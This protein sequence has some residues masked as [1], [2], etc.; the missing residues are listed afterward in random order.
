MKKKDA[1]W[2]KKV[3]FVVKENLFLYKTFDYQTI[4]KNPRC[5]DS[6]SG[7]LR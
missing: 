2:R 6:I 5:P 3:F 4:D 7:T 1:I